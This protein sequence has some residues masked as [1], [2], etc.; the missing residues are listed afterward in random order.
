MF[1][2]VAAFR[3]YEFGDPE[4]ATVS[5]PFVEVC[6]CEVRHAVFA[7]LEEPSTASQHSRVWVAV[8]KTCCLAATKMIAVGA[9]C[10]GYAVGSVTS[11]SGELRLRTYVGGHCVEPRCSAPENNAVQHIM[12]SVTTNQNHQAGDESPVAM[13]V[14]VQHTVPIRE[15]NT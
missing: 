12:A 14:L 11:N 10:S 6:G 5:F 8:G 4:T 9:V 3:H 7:A 1:V 2:W 15:A 13:V